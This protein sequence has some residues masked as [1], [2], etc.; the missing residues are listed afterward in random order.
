M[1]DCTHCGIHITLEE[2]PH[3]IDIRG[4]DGINRIYHG[5]CADELFFTGNNITIQ[6]NFTHEELMDIELLIKSKRIDTPLGLQR[7]YFDNILKKF[8]ELK[9][10]EDLNV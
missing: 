6:T 2:Y 10:L 9:P 7:E 8:K 1:A 3:S 5:Y 4:D